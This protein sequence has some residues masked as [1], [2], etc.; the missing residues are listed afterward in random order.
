MYIIY[1]SFTDKNESHL[2]IKTNVFD[3][4]DV[5]FLITSSGKVIVSRLC[6]HT[7]QPHT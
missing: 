5:K 3:N 1:I 6:T 4:L 2:Y 7:F